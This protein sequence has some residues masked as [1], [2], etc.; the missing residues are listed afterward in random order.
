MQEKRK[1]WT[2]FIPFSYFLHYRWQGRNEGK[3]VI[4][5]LDPAEVAG[6]LSNAEA[7]A[8]QQHRDIGVFVVGKRGQRASMACCQVNKTASPKTVLWHGEQL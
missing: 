7:T 2:R 5:C 8:Q 6:N 1:S 4:C 3:K